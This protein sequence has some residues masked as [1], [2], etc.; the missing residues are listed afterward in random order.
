VCTLN[1]EKLNGKFDTIDKSKL[2]SATALND[3][4]IT[5][6][7]YQRQGSHVEPGDHRVHGQ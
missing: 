5:V 6:A 2:E 3:G 1:D 4:H 7:G